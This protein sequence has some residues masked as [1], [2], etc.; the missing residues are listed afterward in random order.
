MTLPPEQ[1]I[2]SFVLRFVREGDGNQIRWRGRIR[3]VQSNQEISFSYLIQALHFIRQ[4]LQAIAPSS[5]E[6]GPLWR[7]LNLGE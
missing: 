1:E 3:H 7:D 4:Q 6:T 5:V 2:I